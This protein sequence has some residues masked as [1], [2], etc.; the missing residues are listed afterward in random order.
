MPWTLPDTYLESSRDRDATWSREAGDSGTRLLYPSSRSAYRLH[1][2]GYYSFVPIDWP[3]VYITP[4]SKVTRPVVPSRVT[5]GTTF[6]AT[7]SI[8]PAHTVGGKSVQ[9]LLRYYSGGKWRNYRTVWAK[10]VSTAGGATRYLARVSVPYAN[11]YWAINARSP[12]DAGHADSGW[13]TYTMFK[14]R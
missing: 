9:L 3:T 1:W 10:N 8:Y 14:T 5:R 13:S 2:Q 6:S 12:E 7:G 11:T 4:R